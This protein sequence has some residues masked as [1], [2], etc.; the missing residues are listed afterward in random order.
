M[1]C[2]SNVSELSTLTTEGR[3]V[4]SNEALDGRGGGQCA[5]PGIHSHHVR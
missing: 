5:P 1:L 4:C 3:R 2:S